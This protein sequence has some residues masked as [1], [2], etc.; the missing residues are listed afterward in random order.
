MITEHTELAFDFSD[1]SVNRYFT[2]SAVFFDIE[3]TGFSPAR[4]SLY[5]IGCATRRGN[6]L[7]LDQFFAKSPAEEREVLDA[8][9]ALLAKKGDHPHL[10]R[11]RIRHP[12][13]E[14][15]MPESWC[16]LPFRE[17]CLPRHLQGDLAAKNT[18]GSSEFKAEID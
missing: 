6:A 15:E 16:S 12:L 3:T 17:P 5:L 10:Q 8:F 11:R 4:T 13:P 18:A 9:F 2:E 7:C 1:A 14:G